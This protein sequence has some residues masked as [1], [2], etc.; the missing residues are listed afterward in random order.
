M[1]ERLQDLFKKRETLCAAMPPPKM[2]N[3]AISL[4]IIGSGLSSSDD[5]QIDVTDERLCQDLTNVIRIWLLRQADDVE[6]RISGEI[7]KANSPE[8]MSN[9]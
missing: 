8:N 3:R 4:S 2:E 7:K 5:F 6:G 1:F 9:M